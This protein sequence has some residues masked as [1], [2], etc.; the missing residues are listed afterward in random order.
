[1]S[2]KDYDKALWDRFEAT[3]QKMS[4]GEEVEQMEFRQTIGV[5]A[6]MVASLADKAI[7]KDELDAA[8]EKCRQRAKC[9]QDNEELTLKQTFLRIVRN[10]FAGPA[11]RWAVASIVIVWMI[12]HTCGDAI[13]KAI[14]AHTTAVTATTLAERLMAK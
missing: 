2:G 14:V 6:L 1:M 3:A 11:A 13:N 12:L 9:Q 10:V 5:T 7:S 8:I 4:R